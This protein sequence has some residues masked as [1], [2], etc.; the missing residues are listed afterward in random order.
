MGR[1]AL[2][3]NPPCTP[4]TREFHAIFGLKWRVDNRV[5]SRTTIFAPPRIAEANE[6]QLDH[7]GVPKFTNEVQH[8]FEVLPWD[9]VKQPSVALRM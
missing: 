5:D 6:R 2:P 7:L 3:H 4:S 1:E 8:Q 9:Q